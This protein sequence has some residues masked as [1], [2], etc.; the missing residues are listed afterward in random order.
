MPFVS[1][2]RPAIGISLL[3]ASLHRDG[4]PCDI[5]YPTF[6][7]A[8][9]IG[10]PIYER[11]C[12]TTSDTW[13][14]EYVFAQGLFGDTIPPRAAYSLDVLV[15]TLRGDR[16]PALPEEYVEQLSSW[17]GLLGEHAGLFLDECMQA[18]PWSRYA[19]VGF[20]STFHQTTASLAL[21]RRIKREHP[22]INI[23]FGGANCEAEMG[24]A[25]HR[26]FPFIDY[27]CGGEA[28][29]SF[30]VLVR[31]ILEGN[32]V[33]D[34]PGVVRRV[35]GRSV[36]PTA[37]GAPVQDMDALPVPDFDDYVEQRARVLGLDD[38]PQILFEGAR[39]CWWGQK[40]HCT[41]CGLNGE[42]MAFRSKSPQRAV[43]EI[44]QLAERYDTPRI[45]AVD[46][47]IPMSYFN[48]VLPELASCGL[49]LDMFYETKAN[50]KRDQV[51]LLR[52]AGVLSIQPGIESL[53]S[54]VL[55][56]M[57]KGVTS[58]QNI[59]L[60]RWCAEYMI[61]VR[62]N[63]LA[64]FPGETPE[65]Y[66]RQAEIV[67]L[68]VHLPAP[69]DC[70]LLRVDRFSPMFSQPEAHGL[71]RLRPRSAYRYVFP[72]GADTLHDLAYFFD[73]DYSIERQPAAYTQELQQQVRGW[74]AQAGRASLTS[75]VVDDELRIW[76]T[77]P[78]AV[79]RE[80]GLS[81]AHRVVYE[82]CDEA[83]TIRSLQDRIAGTGAVSREAH[84][85]E[86]ILADLIDWKLLL[87]EDDRYLGL[88]VSGQ[89]QLEVLASHLAAGTPLPLRCSA[90]LARLYEVASDVVQTLV[91]RSSRTGPRPLDASAVR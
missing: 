75:L 45:A 41:F 83:R 11:I 72:F 21:A 48:A 2:G 26:L 13:L 35:A 87:Y 62:W 15:P 14:G 71:T 55:R 42:T 53:N 12:E 85:L 1:T 67:P 54:D 20:T 27:L 39:G 61:E 90:P 57:K 63:I 47:I 19:V 5:H 59:Q 88:A 76:D 9:R 50:L 64:G 3:K 28:D 31:E 33:S 49:A 56:I 43:Q 24:R 91:A 81:G 69:L 89:Y 38:P 68:V 74:F 25:L 22:H 7:F 82:Y 86:S 37:S 29:L 34:I 16:D 17:V 73:F 78:T 18:I 44:V 77:R 6:H 4:I 46:N 51:R 60:L 58:A 70:G 36:H 84:R 10:L 23:V 80:H 52:E 30:P 8:R 65:Q 66:S 79:K 40:S 32:G